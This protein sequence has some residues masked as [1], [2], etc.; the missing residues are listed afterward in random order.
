MAILS[1]FATLAA[2]VAAAAF[3]FKGCD[4]LGRA[5]LLRFLISV[6][7]LVA[8]VGLLSSGSIPSIGWSLLIVPVVEEGMRLV[9]LSAS[10][11]GER[12]NFQAALFVAAL[13]AIREMNN[14]LVSWVQ[15][16]VP[17]DPSI[18]LTSHIYLALAFPAHALMDFA[19]HALFGVV[20]V[21]L[22]RRR[23]LRLLVPVGAH[24]GLN[25]LQYML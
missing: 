14:L 5:M 9:T 1:F 25:A 6:A 7:V 17:S 19:G 20:M 16:T 8:I 18:G 10:R 2:T 4:P 11:A 13:F 12:P 3:L 23:I 22:W 21:A 15:G 24:A